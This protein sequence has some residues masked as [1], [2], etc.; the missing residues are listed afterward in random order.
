[1][2]NYRKIHTLNWNSALHMENYIEI[3]VVA[4]LFDEFFNCINSSYNQPG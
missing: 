1:M 3:Q 2:R 4:N